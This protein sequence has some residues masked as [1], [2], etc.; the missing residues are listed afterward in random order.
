MGPKFTWCNNKS[1]GARILEKLDRCLINSI[2]LNSIHLA[3]VKHLSRIASDHCPV[4]LEIFKPAV[5]NKIDIRYEEVWAT[6]HGAEAIVEKSWSKFAGLDPASSLNVKFKRTLRSLFYWSKAKFKN[7]MVLRDRLKE[8]IQEIQLEEGEFGIS[9]EKLQILRF[10]INELNVTLTRLNTWW[11]QRAKAR[12]M[13]EGDCNSGFFHAFANA[14]KNTNWISHI[15][16][17]ACNIMED[18]NEIQK[19]FSEFFKLKW[20]Q[21]NCI[22]DGWPNP[23]A[24][25]N[26]KDQSMLEEEFTRKELQSIIEK[27]GSNIAPGVDGITFSFLKKFWNLIA[28]DVWLAVRHFL[29]SG[30]MHMSWKETIIVL[31]LKNQNPQEVNS[32]RPISLC[33][34]IY[35]VIAKMLLRRL[36]MVIHKLISTDQAA[37]NKGVLCQIMFFWHKKSS[38]NFVI[39]KLGKVF[40]Q[41]SLTW[42]KLMI[43]LVGM[44]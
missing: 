1:G 6:Y 21:R 11:R 42:N 3:M 23:L 15:K 16:T 29:I 37:F 27:S 22:L 8:E 9:L 28:E 30:D 34:T 18:V 2:A 19:V 32:Y 12:W 4:L 13:E 38:T 31:I 36:E 44:L 35:K 41:S 7:L 5:V 43:V 14:K 39:L 24:I 10:K 17:N 26:E 20:Q 25:V 33:L 40:L